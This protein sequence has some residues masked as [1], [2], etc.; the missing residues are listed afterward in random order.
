MW[1][2]GRGCRRA[3]SKDWRDAML[4]NLIAVKIKWVMKH[5]MGAGGDQGARTTPL[6]HARLQKHRERY[7]NFY[8]A[9][10]MEGAWAAGEGGGAA[11]AAAGPAAVEMFLRALAVC[12]TVVP[13]G[14][15]VR[16]MVPGHTGSVSRTSSA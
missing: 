8:D 14:E 15:P 12:H 13:D 3:I 1:G 7:F 4:G 11:A 16:P 2:H 5:K 9:R 6:L 10:L